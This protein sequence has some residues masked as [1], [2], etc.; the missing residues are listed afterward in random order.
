MRRFHAGK[1]ASRRWQATGNKTHLWNLIITVM[2]KQIIL[3][4][5]W[6]NAKAYLESKIYDVVRMRKWWFPHFCKESEF[7]NPE[8]Y[9]PAFHSHLKVLCCLRTA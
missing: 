1:P 2:I 8:P 3:E 7:K 4:V 5:G 9:N 6:H